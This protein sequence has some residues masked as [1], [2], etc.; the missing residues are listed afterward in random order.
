MEALLSRRDAVRAKRTSNVVS[1]PRSDLFAAETEEPIVLNEE[2]T[3][4]PTKPAQTP[5]VNPG[6][7]ESPDHQ[8][9]DNDAMSSRLLAAKRK[10]KPKS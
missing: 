8:Q 2:L 5:Q 10:N 6:K 3:K 1:T 9:E 7:E 4:E